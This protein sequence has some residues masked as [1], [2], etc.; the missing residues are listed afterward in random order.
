MSTSERL[1]SASFGVLALGAAVG[2]SV[3]GGVAAVGLLLLLFY[4][5]RKWI[6]GFF[7]K[8]G[9]SVFAGALA[10]LLVLAPMFR[11]AMRIVNVFEPSRPFEFSVGGTMFIL[12]FI[13]VIMGFV[14]GVSVL[15]LRDGL[16]SSRVVTS[17]L[18][19]GLVLALL[20]TNPEFR[21]ELLELGAGGWMNI[22]M[23][24]LSAVLY[25]WALQALYDRIGFGADSSAKMARAMA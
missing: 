17:L 8:L 14:I 3:V 9:R 13:G 4:G 19:G 1:A 11:L 16:D 21:T 20:L 25:G 12:M 7:R 15:F 23:F 5:G 6:P 10:G 18:T 22:P 24:G 2:G